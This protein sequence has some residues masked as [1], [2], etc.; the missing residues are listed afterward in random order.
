MQSL[1]LKGTLASPSKTSPP[2]RDTAYV[3]NPDLTHFT[4]LVIIEPVR[5]KNNHIRKTVYPLG[6]YTDLRW[7]EYPE[8]IQIY[9]TRWIRAHIKTCAFP[10][11]VSHPGTFV[12][13]GPLELAYR[14]ELVPFEEIVGQ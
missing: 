13:W 3:L 7:E 4:I 8:R 12:Y 14:H 9:I 10:R 6:F 5:G 1:T 2:C 11:Q